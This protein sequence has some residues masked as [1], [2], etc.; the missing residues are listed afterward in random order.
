MQE[1]RIIGHTDLERRQFGYYA[2]GVV[3]GFGSAFLLMWLV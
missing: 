2:F 1:Y 3:V